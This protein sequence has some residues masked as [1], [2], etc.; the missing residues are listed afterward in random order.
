MVV[1]LAENV[2]VPRGAA[3]RP[4]LSERK[5]VAN[6]KPKPTEKSALATAPA[7]S[8]P[9][10]TA[11]EEMNYDETQGGGGTRSELQRYVGS[12]VQRLNEAKRYPR[13]AILR[14]E[15][16]RVI[17]GMRISS[18]GS[19]ADVHIDVPSPFESLNRAALDTM[20]VIGK[21]PP[22][23]TANRSALRLRIP[24]N[25]ELRNQ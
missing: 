17:I 19:V 25:F 4:R 21:L 6:P 14:E 9:S 23:P 12:L 5:P 7:E 20:R 1:D 3:P 24:L 18:D 15:E 16:G 13:A 11:V 22:P 10:E 8:A 2:N